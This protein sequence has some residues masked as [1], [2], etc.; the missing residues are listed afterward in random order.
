MGNIIEKFLLLSLICVTLV[1]FAAIGVFCANVA[2]R[3]IKEK[4]ASADRPR[5]RVN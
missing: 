1:V 5:R 3:F 4:R 2:V